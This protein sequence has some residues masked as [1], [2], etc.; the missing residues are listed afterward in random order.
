M[1]SDSREIAR[2]LRD[3]LAQHRDVFSVIDP[4]ETRQQI[5]ARFPEQ[6]GK[7]QDYLGRIKQF[8]YAEQ[9]LVPLN[10]KFE[11]DVANIL[12]LRGH[13]SSVNH[14][15]AL[16]DGRAISA[17]WDNTLR[18]WDLAS[19]QCLRVLEGHS[20]SVAH[21][22]ALPDG[23]AI[24]ASWDNT[25]RLWDLASG[26]CLRVL[27]GHSDR[28]QPRRGAA[29]RTRD[30]RLSRQN[31]AAL[32]P[33]LRPM[34]A[35]PRRTFRAR[36]P[37]RGAARRTRDLR[38]W[39]QHPAALGP[40][41]R[42]MPARPRRTFRVRH[43]RRGAARRTRDLRFRGQHPAALGP[44]LRPM[45]ARPRRTFRRRRPRRGAARRTR[46]LRLHDNTLRLWDLASG[47]CLRVLEG[48]SSPVTHVAAL[49]DGRAISASDDNTLR[50]WDLASGQCLRVL[51]GHSDRSS[52]TSRRC[53]TDARSP[54][55]TTTPCGSGTSPPANACA[56]SKDIPRPS[57]TSR[58]CPTDARSPPL[59]DHTLR[60]WDLASGQCLR[61]LEGHSWPVTHVAALPDGRAI[62]ASCDNTL[63]LWD[64]ASGQCLRVLEGHSDRGQPRRGAARRTRDLRFRRQH[65][66]ALG[67]RLRPMPARPRRTFRLGQP[68]RGAARRTRDLR[69]MGQHPAAL[70]PRLRPMPAR[71][72]RTFRQ[73]HPRRGAA[74]RT[75]DLRL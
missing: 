16:P 52:P 20:W 29:R 8:I 36:H 10:I 40:R 1:F 48:H 66:A 61:V 35:R 32:G 13:S 9:L 33:R 44:R 56:S 55:L 62:S 64:L 60:L 42:P 50:L 38:F 71:P 24:S 3:V 6:G 23:R 51:E 63:R 14:V 58:R 17:S 19:G 2:A 68:R 74:R 57:S 59:D 54:P 37:R 28:R 34:P 53:P 43:P 72:R 21:V 15:A 5:L 75:R 39:G 22:A 26:Q 12:T 31:P 30:L 65:P 67:P 25:L 27:E 47:Q 70:G 11:R 7:F 41:L 49:P 69:F 18:L 45:P 46:D 73:R 4:S